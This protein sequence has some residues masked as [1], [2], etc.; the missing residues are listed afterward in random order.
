MRCSCAACMKR[1]RRSQMPRQRPPDYRE[2]FNA[3]RRE[4]RRKLSQA[5]SRHWKQYTDEESILIGVWSADNVPTTEQA[6]RL[7][8]TPKAVRQ[9]RWKWGLEAPMRGSPA[10]NRK[11][12][13]GG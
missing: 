12:G 8:R 4:R 9:V 5:A 1:R 7:G 3:Y 11:E 2:K 10:E 6:R 13:Q